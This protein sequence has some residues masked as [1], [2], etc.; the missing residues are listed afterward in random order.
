MMSVPVFEAKN[1]LSELLTLVESGQ[2]I[3]ITRRGIPV[4]KL[5]AA[6][7]ESSKIDDVAQIFDLLRALT[8]GLDLDGTLN[9]IAREGLD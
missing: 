5:V 2:E 8:T 7:V 4:A 6:G 3:A 1:R 9:A